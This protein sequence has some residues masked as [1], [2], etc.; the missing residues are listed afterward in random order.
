MHVTLVQATYPA[1]GKLKTTLASNR[2]AIPAEILHR[3]RSGVLRGRVGPIHSEPRTEPIIDIGFDKDFHS[4]YTLGD[5]TSSAA[6]YHAESIARISKCCG[7]VHASIAISGTVSKQV[8][9]M[10]EVV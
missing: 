7:P 4:I 2:Q 1:R 8:G 6:I 5:D 10:V 9:I 3:R